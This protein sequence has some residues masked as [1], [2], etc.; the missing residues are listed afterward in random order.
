VRFAVVAVVI[1]VYLRLSAVPLLLFLL[2]LLFAVPNL[3]HL[4]NLRMTAVF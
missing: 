1:R 4:R 3:S 2:F